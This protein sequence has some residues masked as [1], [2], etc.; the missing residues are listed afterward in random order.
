MDSGGILPHIYLHCGKKWQSQPCTGMLLCWVPGKQANSRALLSRAA[1]MCCLPG[2]RVVLLGQ[3]SPRLR[4]A[5]E[6]WSPSS[7]KGLVGSGWHGQ[8]EQEA[9]SASR[10]PL[11]SDGGSPAKVSILLYSTRDVKGFSHDLGLVRSQTWAVLLS[12]WSMR[13]LCVL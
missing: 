8:P 7:P 1:P 2:S 4:S 13:Y 3:C 12:L 9:N 11:L 5:C 6:G 10:S